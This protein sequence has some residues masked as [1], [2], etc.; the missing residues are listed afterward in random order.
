MS[1]NDNDEICKHLNENVMK[2]LDRS[3]VTK[4]RIRKYARK[5]REYKLTY[6]LLSQLSTS[7]DTEVDKSIIEHLTKVF[8]VH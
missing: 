1:I 6:N 5:A 7:E 2:A 3:C 4:K 8:K